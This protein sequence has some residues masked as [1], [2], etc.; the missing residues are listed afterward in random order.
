MNFHYKIL[1]HFIC[2]FISGSKCDERIPYFYLHLLRNARDR[3]ENEQIRIF[4]RF[5]RILLRLGLPHPLRLN[6]PYILRLG[7]PHPR[8]LGLHHPLRLGLARRPWLGPP[9][10]AG[11]GPSSKAGP[12]SSPEAGSS[13]SSKGGRSPSSKAGPSSSRKAV[14][15]G[16]RNSSRGVVGTSANHLL[17]CTRYFGFVSCD[18]SKV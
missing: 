17:L 18:G 10:K 12:S 6:L 14:S 4:N 15:S 3:P 11:L 16:H 7:H 2:D 9:S 13:P 8:R 5:S 1:N